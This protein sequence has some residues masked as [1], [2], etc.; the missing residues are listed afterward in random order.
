M[1]RCALRK[2]TE[3]RMGCRPQCRAPRV[4][5]VCFRPQS[6]HLGQVEAGFVPLGTVCKQN[7]RREAPPVAAHSVGCFCR[8]GHQILRLSLENRILTPDRAQKGHP[9]RMWP[10]WGFAGSLESIYPRARTNALPCSVPFS[11]LLIPF[12]SA[13]PGP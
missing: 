4:V 11:V 3:P 9:G 5:P 6:S 2:A 7:H 8:A 13:C 12:P 1:K 10:N